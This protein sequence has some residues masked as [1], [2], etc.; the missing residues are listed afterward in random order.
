VG[1]NLVLERLGWAMNGRKHW[2]FH[3]RLKRRRKH[4]RSTA[5]RARHRAAFD[6]DE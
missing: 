1:T 2:H 4:F 5:G 3:E 6:A